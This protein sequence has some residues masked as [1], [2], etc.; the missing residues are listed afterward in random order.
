MREEWRIGGVTIALDHT[1]IGDF[2]E[3]EGESADRV[4]RRCGFD[5]DTAERRNYLE[6][7]DAHR[8]ENPG[9]TVDMVFP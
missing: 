7:Y 4:A 9:A 6:L 5:P 3:F 8:R 1:P 2:V